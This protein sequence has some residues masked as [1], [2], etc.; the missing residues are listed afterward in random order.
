MMTNK[1]HLHTDS[2]GKWKIQ[3]DTDVHDIK[4]SEDFTKTI[5]ERFL[6]IKLTLD[7]KMVQILN[8]ILSPETQDIY[9]RGE[10]VS[11]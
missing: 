5:P 9:L 3:L 8:E 6:S 1:W 2:S 4:I 7:A 10:L 11:E